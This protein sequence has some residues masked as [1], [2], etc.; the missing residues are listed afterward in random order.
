MTRAF[1]SRAALGAALAAGLASAGQ[2]AKFSQTPPEGFRPLDLT[3]LLE[4]GPLATREPQTFDLGA[5]LTLGACPAGAW[6]G[7]STFQ[8]LPGGTVEFEGQHFRCLPFGEGTVLYPNGARYTG[9]VNS[10][11]RNP[12][13]PGL[14]LGASAANLRLDAASVRVAVREGRG[15]ATSPEGKAVQ[16]TFLRGDV[17]A[18]EKLVGRS[19]VRVKAFDAA[20]AVLAANARTALEAEQKAV[21]MVALEQE[22]KAKAAA[23]KAAAEKARAAE[24]AR[25]ENVAREEI[26]GL[27]NALL[28]EGEFPAV[29]VA[30]AAPAPAAAPD[31]SGLVLGP[32]D[33]P[34]RTVA[35]AAAYARQVVAETDLTRCGPDPALIPPYVEAQGAWARSTGVFKP[36]TYDQ[37]LSRFQE[38]ARKLISYPPLAELKELV[39]VDDAYNARHGGGAHNVNGLIRISDVQARMSYAEHLVV[40][41]MRT[42][43][44]ARKERAQA[45]LAEARSG[46]NAR[47]AAT[48]PAPDSKACRARDRR[49][50]DELNKLATSAPGVRYQS[51]MYEQLVAQSVRLAIL[52]PC[53]NAGA[54]PDYKMALDQLVWTLEFCANGNETCT[55]SDADQQRWVDAMLPIAQR[56]EGSAVTAPA[57]KATDPAA[58]ACTAA[59]EGQ[60]R[61]FHAIYQRRPKDVELVPDFQT[62]LAMLDARIALLDKSCQGQPESRERAAVAAARAQAE[63]NCRALTTSADVCR[64]EIAW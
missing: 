15:T 60:E 43:I 58:Q 20:L 21:R 39:R 11:L 40:R 22:A 56:V 12:A 35:E 34:R 46:D 4:T 51:R 57:P 3:L 27:R 50:A 17:V 32:L 29:A 45:Y 13:A 5:G 2:P 38:Q 37:A 7:K 31:Q 42:C 64:P 59:Y 48:R 63:S 10:Y 47:V 18:P 62:L 26:A 25:R 6:K 9:T 52:R 28:G 44:I 55:T 49:I 16:G 14:L 54:D 19:A 61:Y 33:A 24:R 8:G 1:A 53:A 41:G 23:E 36:T 30:A